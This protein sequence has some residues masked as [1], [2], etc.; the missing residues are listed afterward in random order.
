MEQLYDLILEYFHTQACAIGFPEL[1]LPA[2][3]QVL[4]L[5]KC[6]HNFTF[7]SNSYH[8]SNKS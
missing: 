1:A 3:V 2:I 6:F 8:I 5:D 7:H 4:F